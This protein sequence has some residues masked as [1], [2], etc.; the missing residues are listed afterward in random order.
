MGG[1]A[2]RA[3]GVKMDTL[4]ITG[5]ESILSVAAISWSCSLCI[6]LLALL[7]ISPNWLKPFYPEFKAVFGL[8]GLALFTVHASTGH[9]M[10][11]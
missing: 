2:Q 8:L 1:A 5:V 10:L 3:A 6:S 7:F 4:M 11:F 9:W